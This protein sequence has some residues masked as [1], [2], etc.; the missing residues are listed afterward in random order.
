VASQAEVDLVISTADT[1]PQLERDLS[2]I[3]RTAEDGAET[4][5]VEAALAVGQS[6]SNLAD[7]LD[8]VI[9]AA[10][11]GAD[12]I[13][14]DAALDAQRSLST[15]QTQLESIRQRVEDGTPIDLRAEVDQLGSLTDIQGQIRSIVREAEATAP[16]IE[17]DVDIDRDGSGS[18]AL[19]RLGRGITSVLGPISRL[20]PA[21]AAV[22]AAGASLGPVL[23]GVVAA[24]QQLAPASA[25]AATGL[26]SVALAGGTV[27]L[28]MVGIE[29]AVKAALDPSDPEA[30]AEALEKLS[31]NAQEFAKEIRNLQPQ[32][33][34]FQQEIQDTVFRNFAQNLRDLSGS[35]LPVLSDGL[36]ST[37]TTLNLMAQGVVD[38]ASELANNGTLGRAVASASRG[39]AEFSQVP[40]QAVTALGQLA[41]AAGP[42]FER[43]SAAA[44]RAAGD[45]SD[46]LTEAFESGRLEAAIDSAVDAF[47]QLG[48]IAGNVFEGLGNIVEGFQA[49]GEGLFG[50]LEKVTR[51]FADVTAT[52]G[53][54][55]ALQALTAVMGTLVSTVL[56]ILSQA[57]QALGPV[58][59]VLAAPVQALIKV[60]GTALTQIVSA[61]G[62]V[63]VS[64]GSAFGKLL[65]ALSPIL[66][67]LGTLISAV[68]PVLTPL[69]DALGQIFE[70]V[71]PFIEQMA[72]NLEAQLVPALTVLATEVLPQV[73]PPLVELGTRIFPI[74]TKI[75]TDLAPTIGRLGQ[76]FAQLLVAMTPVILQ[77]TALTAEFIDGLMPVLLPLIDLLIRVVDVGMRAIS[78]F[79]TAVLIPALGILVD[80]LNGDFSAAWNKTK[81]LIANVARASVEAIQ[82]FIRTSSQGFRDLAAQAVERVQSMARDVVARIREMGTNAVNDIRS[83]PSRA[84]A[85]LGDLG[86]VLFSAGAN[87]VRGFI[88]GIRSQIN[89]L[90]STARNMASAAKDAV[91]G[92][93]GIH[94]PSTVMREV[95][96][97]TGQG[98]LLGFRDMVPDLRREF[99]SVAALAPT[100]AMPE[101]TQMTAFQPPTST[102]P[103]VQVF[104]GNELL[105]QRVD[106]RIAESN[107]A[108]DRLFVRGVRR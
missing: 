48:R 69:F 101:G 50:T 63:L 25:V 97:D 35:V 10:E 84:S 55:Q 23:A 73:L 106:T 19:G 11:N 98:F 59:S 44:A 12:N 79:I 66:S 6:L 85:A 83:L 105:D 81:E 5:D 28:A 22:G 26:L 95:G 58:L 7:E 9:T 103:T 1:L 67:L 87:L 72:K 62:P 100:F 56:P 36:R 38:A 43:I 78:A 71:T 33:K 39:L 70:A 52:E 31:P 54:Q 40:G 99:A 34:A 45:V 51:A 60:L 57:L 76:T 16:D 74:L 32:L 61:L 89:S 93:L 13:E 80:L 82:N 41:A 108:R 20:A 75:I 3:I 91:T 17:I 42:S 2:R 14:L 4:L 107:Q 46:R 104:L 37:A 94:S 21:L 92:F 27:K 24:T 15:I 30:F 49:Q 88:D 96:A 53:F 47:K 65:T 29:D 102:V 64:L 86:S 90:V 18:R 8:A 68:L 77:I